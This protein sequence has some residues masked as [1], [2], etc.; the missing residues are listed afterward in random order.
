MRA[1]RLL[2]IMILLKNKGIL[3]AGELAQEMEVSERTIYRDID[4]LCTAGVPIYAS[5][6]PGGGYELIDEYRVDLTGLSTEELRA[7]FML[8]IPAPIEHL[9]L[10]QTLRGAILKLVASLPERQ[11]CEQD[12]TRQRIYIDFTGW[13]PPEKRQPLLID[14]HKSIWEEKKIL[15]SRRLSFGATDCSDVEPLGLVS[16][17]DQWFLICKFRGGIKVIRTDQILSV[18]LTT[19]TFSRP[20]DFDLFRFWES[21]RH[22]IRTLQPVFTVKALVAPSGISLIKQWK[23]YDHSENHECASD[24][25]D[26]EL[27]IF[28][29]DNLETARSKIL[30]FG[31]IVEVLEPE[32]LRLSICDFATQIHELYKSHD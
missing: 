9:G 1:D 31:N 10:S 13:H 26:L 14:I 24:L 19:Q 18:E 30:A 16:K 21:W 29:F 6:G 2:A 17:E 25:A 3:T 22:D 27:M 15:L 23:E 4:V 8:N 7:L 20:A 32:A 12:I 28:K 5:H 11:Q